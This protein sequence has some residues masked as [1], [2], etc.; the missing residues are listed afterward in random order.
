MKTSLVSQTL[1]FFIGLIVSIGYYAD[2][3][4]ASSIKSKW[5]KCG[6]YTISLDE[7]KETFSVKTGSVTKQ[8][9]AVFYPEQVDFDDFYGQTSDGI[10]KL[11][12]SINRKNLNYQVVNYMR[13][14][15]YGKDTGWVQ[16]GKAQ[17]GICILIKNPNEGNK[18]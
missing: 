16:V 11:V 7:S 6:T 15:L 12:Y 4:S 17:E 9:K 14:N 10:N 2:A 13:M 1:I 18:I 5:L 3:S 8:G